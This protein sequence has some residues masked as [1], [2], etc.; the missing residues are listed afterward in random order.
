MAPAFQAR[1]ARRIV[2]PSTVNRG[3]REGVKFL[4]ETE[5]REGGSLGL[6]IKSSW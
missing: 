5:I 1:V 6:E 4:L 2:L 3:V